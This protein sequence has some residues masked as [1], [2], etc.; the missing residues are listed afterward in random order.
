MALTARPFTISSW[1]EL[2]APGSVSWEVGRFRVSVY[3]NGFYPL[4]SCLKSLN[5]YH[6]L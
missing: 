1:V 3:G 2:A 5:P 4:L 6:S